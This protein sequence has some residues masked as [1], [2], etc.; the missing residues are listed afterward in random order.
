[1]SAD[2]LAQLD[3]HYRSMPPVRALQLSIEAFDGERLRLSAPLAANVNDKGCAFGGS[4]ASLMTLACW[5]RVWLGL[6]A[7]GLDC[8]IYVADSRIRYL[9]PLYAD[10]HA[11]AALA[12]DASWADFVAAVGAR[13]RGRIDLVARVDVPGGGPATTF[14]ARFVAIRR[15]AA[16]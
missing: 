4:L 9:A 7:V 16:A 6:H 13:G 14:E 2:P 5:G 15:P 3:A 10:L 8:D 11:E 1:M 12:P